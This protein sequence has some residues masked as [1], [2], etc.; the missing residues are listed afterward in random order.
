MAGDFFTFL[1][2]NM[3]SI[4][5]FVVI[6]VSSCIV[7]GLGIKNV[8]T[9]TND[10]LVKELTSMFAISMAI[11]ILAFIISLFLAKSNPVAS[12]TYTSIMLHL[13]LVLSLIALSYSTLKLN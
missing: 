7:A 8:N 12:Q 5:L 3:I 13:S 6:A 10:A 9:N 2:N 4:P 11:V 1:K